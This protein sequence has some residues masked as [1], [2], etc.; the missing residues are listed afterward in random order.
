M[1]SSAIG[2]SITKPQR[3]LKKEQTPQVLATK[4]KAAAEKWLPLVKEFGI[5]AE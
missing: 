3:Q 5:Q 4:Q 2:Y 1:W